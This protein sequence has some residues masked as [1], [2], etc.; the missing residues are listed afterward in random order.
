ML[1][2]L[3]A[4][5]AENRQTPPS[6]NH[7][8][9]RRVGGSSSLGDGITR[10]IEGP[11]AVKEEPYRRPVTSPTAAAIVAA[12]TCSITLAARLRIVLLSESTV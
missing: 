10:L 2:G 6:S 12:V 8:R 9:T 5:N 1:S 7:F 4:T 11:F 3:V